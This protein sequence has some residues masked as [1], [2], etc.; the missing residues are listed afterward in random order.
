MTC[1][2]LLLAA[3]LDILC[4]TRTV[5]QRHVTAAEPLV[6][7][8]FRRRLEITAVLLGSWLVRHGRELPR[9]TIDLGLV[10]DALGMAILRR[11]PG[12]EST[13]LHSD[14]GTQYTSRAFVK[15]LREAGLLGSMG[16]V[17]NCQLTGQS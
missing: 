5:R 16:T 2:Y 15:R 17:G 12:G 10:V 1:G 13:I 6:T 4:L 8:T 3:A 14:H 7:D 11:R 9:R